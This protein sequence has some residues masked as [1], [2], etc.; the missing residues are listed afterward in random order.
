[1][2]YGLFGLCSTSVVR[3]LIDHVPI[4]PKKQLRSYTIKGPDSKSKSTIGV[5]LYTRSYYINK[6]I[7]DPWPESAK[8]RGLQVTWRQAYKNII[9]I[10]ICLHGHGLCYRTLRVNNRNNYHP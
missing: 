8:L 7:C 4:F 1:M 3:I 2:R 9:Y 6:A 10:Y 5:V